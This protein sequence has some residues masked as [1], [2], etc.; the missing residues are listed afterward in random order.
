M[1]RSDS[2]TLSIIIP[3]LMIFMSAC[4]GSQSSPNDNQTTNTAPTV[5]IT[6]PD[7][8]STFTD[9]DEI[10]FTAT[11]E[12][13]EDGDLST[14][15][16]WSSNLDG[17][18]GTGAEIKSQL[19]NGSHQITATIT[20]ANNSSA[21]ATINLLIKPTY[22]NASLSW[23]APTTNSDGSD[24]TDLDGFIIYYGDSEDN[25]NQSII[26][27]DSNTLTKLITN[28][29]VDKTYY[30]AVVSVNS[31]GVESDRSEIVSKYISG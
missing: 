31:E 8:N 28:L 23:I 4:G 25:L 26:I 14:S 3:L 20:D 30:F 15:I 22:G 17:S 13:T 9:E 12:D 18:L 6:S 19:S 7:D 2:K 11:A 24:L 29:T 16:V 10:T 27:N 1:Y 5:T 21:S